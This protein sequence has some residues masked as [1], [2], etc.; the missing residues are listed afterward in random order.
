MKDIVFKRNVRRRRRGGR[1][2]DVPKQSY[3]V[4]RV[5]VYGTNGVDAPSEMDYVT[6]ESLRWWFGRR[7]RGHSRSE[8]CFQLLISEK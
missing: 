7:V 5:D 6:T 4:V 8:V 2:A 3:G 1:L